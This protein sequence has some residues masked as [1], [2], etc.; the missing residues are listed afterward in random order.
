MLSNIIQIISYRKFYS[1]KTTTCTF[2]TN[3]LNYHREHISKWSDDLPSTQKRHNLFQ[4][5]LFLY[6]Y[7]VSGQATPDQHPNKNKKST[8]HVDGIFNNVDVHQTGR[9]TKRRSF[10]VSDVH[11][12]RINKPASVLANKVDTIRSPSIL[13]LVEDDVYWRFGVKTTSFA[14]ADISFRYKDVSGWKIVG[15][16]TKQF[17]LLLR[18][19]SLGR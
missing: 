3:V 18:V 17:N 7:F 13:G 12:A 2:F 1:F 9:R 19:S 4:M 14:T 11:R 6:I 15:S 16:N 10:P 8:A 5:S